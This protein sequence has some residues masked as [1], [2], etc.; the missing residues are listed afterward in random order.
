MLCWELKFFFTGEP[1]THI[2]KMTYTFLRD[3]LHKWLLL[4]QRLR[5]SVGVPHLSNPSRSA[6]TS[7]RTK[8][9]WDIQCA[10]QVGLISADYSDILV[11]Q[12]TTKII[13]IRAGLGRT[14]VLDN[15]NY[16]NWTRLFVQ[17]CEEAVT[18]NKIC[19]NFSKLKNSFWNY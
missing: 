2:H 18:K 6:N 7:A 15:F 3:T 11:S 19:R 12:C 13:L 9:V 16:Q 4:F 1:K 5:L 17:K 8:L 10:T 14:I